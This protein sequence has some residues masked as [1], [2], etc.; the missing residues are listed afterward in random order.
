MSRNPLAPL[1]QCA[2]HVLVVPEGGQDDDPGRGAAVD[3]AAC[4]LEAVDLRH[5]DVHQGDIR[6]GRA[7]EGHRL[8]AVRC[9][10]DHVDVRLR[11][12]DRGDPITDELVVVGDDNPDHGRGIPGRVARTTKPVERLGPAVTE[13]PH[14]VTRSRIPFNPFPSAGAS[15]L[16]PAPWSATSMMTS[17]WLRLRVTSVAA[18]AAC[19]MTLV[20]P[21]WTTRYAAWLACGVKAGSPS[22]WRNVTATPASRT[23]SS[24]SLCSCSMAR[25]SCCDPTARTCYDRGSTRD[26]RLCAVAV[27]GCAALVTQAWLA[28]YETRLALVRFDAV[29]LYLTIGAMMVLAALRPAGSRWLP[30]PVATAGVAAGCLGIGYPND[31]YSPGT[32]GGILLT[33]LSLTFLAAAERA[34]R[35][36][37]QLQPS[38]PAPV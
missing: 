11:F 30:W 10:T 29:G 5:P 31:P 24:S 21:S 23:L 16:G 6:G 35:N 2:E 26:A 18:L 12:E 19:R 3:E 33:A 36:P 20:S 13:P 32:V 4:R 34:N 15:A 28:S 17:S 7:D 37:T 25:W 38:D 9:G 1:A 27:L 14:A 22:S 8:D